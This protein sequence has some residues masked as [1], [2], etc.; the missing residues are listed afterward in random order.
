MPKGKSLDTITAE[1]EQIE[2]VWTDNPT[3]SLGDLTLVKFQ[4]LLADLRAKRDRLQQIRAEET[5]AIN[6]VNAQ[7]AAVDDANTRIRSGIRATYGPD[8]NQYEQ[9][10][11]TRTSERKRPARKAKPAGPQ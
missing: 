6:E 1:A 10:G 9:A 7:G 8:S 3:L 4:S 11:G 5:A 2:R